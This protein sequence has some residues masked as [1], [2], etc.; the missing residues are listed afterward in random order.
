MR[1]HCVPLTKSLSLRNTSK[2]NNAKILSALGRMPGS[3]SDVD[4]DAA[5][6]R[7]I[8]ADVKST[9]PIFM[10]TTYEF[11]VAGLTGLSIFGF[12]WQ[13]NPFA[14]K[15]VAKSWSTSKDRRYDKVVLRDDLTWSDGKPITAHDVVF[16]FKL[17]MDPR[18][19]VP[20][21][22]TGTDQIRW[23]EAYDDHTL[24]FFHK[25]S[26]ATNIWNVNF[27]VIPKHIYEHYADDPTL[28]NDPRFVK[29][30]NDPV[31]GGPYALKERRRD[32]EIVLE[33]RESWFMHQGKQVRPKPYFKT[34]RFRILPD[35]NTALLCAEKWKS[36]RDAA[37]SA[38]RLADA[39]GQ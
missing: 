28:Q 3:D 16:S 8:A 29:Y 2:E 17:I 4:W 23:I 12:D 6:V 37:G 32:E 1:S 14:S 20:A 38:V 15:S 13:F 34:I 35:S 19:P 9:N 5:F 36:G 31:V 25:Q 39:D 18:V 7:Q 24:V 33:R 27:P 26:A 22:R 30:E 21:V 10:N 11:D